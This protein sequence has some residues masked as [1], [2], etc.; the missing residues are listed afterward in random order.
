MESMSSEFPGHTKNGYSLTF[1]ECSKS[2]FRVIPWCEIT[3][4]EISLLLEHN[5]LTCH[6]NSMNNFTLVFC[7]IHVTIHYSQRYASAANGSPDLHTYWRF[8]SS[9]NTLSMV[10]L[11]LFAPNTTMALIVMTHVNALC[12][13]RMGTSLCTF[14]HDIASCHNSKRH[15][16]FLECNGMPF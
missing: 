9:M 10:F 16:V 5:V 14:M 12:S 6:F 8:Y 1:C 13:H 7:T 2:F 11:I 15:R 4:E 3:Y